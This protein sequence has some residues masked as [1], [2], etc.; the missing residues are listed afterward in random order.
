MI[1]YLAV[2][3]ALTVVGLLAGYSLGPGLF[4]LGVVLLALAP[5][6]RR[7]MLF[8]PPVAAALAWVAA[9][10]ASAPLRCTATETVTAQSTV[11][12][13]SLLGVTSGD[14]AAMMDAAVGFAGAAA[15]TVFIVALAIGRVRA[16]T[17]ATSST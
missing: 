17:A 12:C 11:T 16:R 14:P 2:T 10:Y 5:V 1:R 8:W 15:V 9:W 13:S 6:R 3:F 7:P 4:L